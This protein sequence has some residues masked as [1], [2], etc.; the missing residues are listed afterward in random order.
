MVLPSQWNPSRLC[1]RG[2][3][4]KDKAAKF[5][6]SFDGLG[7]IRVGAEHPYRRDLPTRYPKNLYQLKLRGQC[8]LLLAEYIRTYIVPECFRLIARARDPA[9]EGSELDA[10]RAADLLFV[11]VVSLQ[12][13]FRGPPPSD[14]AGIGGVVHIGVFDTRG[15]GSEAVD[16]T[17]AFATAFGFGAAP[18]KRVRTSAAAVTRLLEGVDGDSLLLRL[19][20]GEF[21]APGPGPRWVLLAPYAVARGH[22]PTFVNSH[23]GDKLLVEGGEMAAWGADAERRDFLLPGGEHGEHWAIRKAK[24]VPHHRRDFRLAT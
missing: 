22:A 12:P 19:Q 3:W 10:I 13:S 24:A 14:I 20:A 5:V 6:G 9:A 15:D 21:D 23:L 8:G 17:G 4:G 16:A 11:L 1:I 2:P 7:K 18:A